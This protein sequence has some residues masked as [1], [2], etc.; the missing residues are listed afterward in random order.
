M[1]LE[2][3]IRENTAAVKA[4]TAALA[5]AGTKPA[6]KA[7]PVADEGESEPETPAAKPAKPAKVEK[8]AKVK[9]AP[10][11]EPE[12]DDEDMLGGDEEEAAPAIDLKT[13]REAG[14]AVIKAGKSGE[15]KKILTKYGAENLTGVAE[16]DYGT[17]YSAIKKI[18]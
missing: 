14:M 18:G 6:V 10:A 8:P 4:L 15:L 1:S 2:E 5:T 16:K 13:L 12:A 11:P 3:A 9:P 17:V 7:A